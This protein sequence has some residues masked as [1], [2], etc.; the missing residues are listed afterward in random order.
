MVM[1][2]RDSL[3]QEKDV[4]NKIRAILDI[5]ATS[6]YNIKEELWHGEYPVKIEP[7]PF[8]CFLFIIAVNPRQINPHRYFPNE[9]QYLRQ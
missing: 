8:P 7:S 4:L 3:P 1:F 2:K 5:K 9:C 6:F